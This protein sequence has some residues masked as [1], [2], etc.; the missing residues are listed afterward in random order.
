M[1]G[2]QIGRDVEIGY[3]VILDNLYPEKITIEDGATITA[4]S[5]VLAIR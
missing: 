2:V 4:R 1:R 5:T 3:F